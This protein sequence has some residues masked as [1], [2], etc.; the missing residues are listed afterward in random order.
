LA[1]TTLKDKD[2]QS[3]SGCRATPRGFETSAVVRNSRDDRVAR[4]RGALNRSVIT[5]LLCIAACKDSAWTPRG[6]ADIVLSEI[7]LRGAVGV[8]KRLDTD[9]TFARSVMTGIA[10]GDSTWLL[11]A[12]SI[13]P[14]SAAA[15]A[16]LQIALAS[17]LVQSPTRV[18]AIVKGRYAVDQVCGIP[19]LRP[20][21]SG[22]VSYHQQALTALARVRDSSLTKTVQ[23]C[24]AALDT[25][26]R[27]KLARID[28][29]YVLKNKPGTTTPVRK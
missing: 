28:P 11:V 23:S 8:S 1:G 10:S 29:G 17:A 9:E 27:E 22:I 18:L 4:I 6:S 5:A 20:D 19:F 15:E 14:E 13:K 16:S 21:S 2:A 12:S 7:K 3:P 26:T 24:T 25:A